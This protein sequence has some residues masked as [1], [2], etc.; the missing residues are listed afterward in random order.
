MLKERT[1]LGQNSVMGQTGQL[2]WSKGSYNR[3]EVKI[4]GPVVLQL[5]EECAPAIDQHNRSRQGDLALEKHWVTKDWVFRLFTTITGMC[6]VDAWRVWVNVAQPAQ[7]HESLLD[8]VDVLAMEHFTNIP[9]QARFQSH[10]L[11][12]RLHF[13]D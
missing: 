4:P 13:M 9:T 3:M 7:K 6:V 12:T 5:Y 10:P 8:F 1:T 11:P 2:Q